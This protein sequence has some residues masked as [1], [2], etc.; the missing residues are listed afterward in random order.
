MKRVW[1]LAGM[2]MAV[3]AVT[4]CGTNLQAAPTNGPVTTQVSHVDVVHYQPPE[5]LPK[6]IWTH[7]LPYQGRVQTAQRTPTA[8]T[9][10]NVL[11]IGPTQG[12]AITQFRSVRHKLRP[13]PDVVWVGTTAALAKREW[14]ALGYKHDPLPSAQTEY[15]DQSLPVPDAFHKNRTGY[16]QL[17]GVLRPNQADQWVRFFG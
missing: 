9:A 7:L 1:I 3:V 17:N 10:A 15:L 14:R 12:F 13:T 4:G 16:A 11:Y 5:T 2:L 8:T 6:S